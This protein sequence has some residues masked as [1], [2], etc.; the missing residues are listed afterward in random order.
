MNNYTLSSTYYLVLENN[1]CLNENLPDD[2][3]VQ[4]TTI[5]FKNKKPIELQ[6]VLIANTDMT[7]DIHFHKF[8]E[9]DLIITKIIDKDVKMNMNMNLDE[10]AI[11]HTF[12]ENNSIHTVEAYCKDE[13]HLNAH[14]SLQSGYA[15]LSD[16][17]FK[18]DYHYYLDGEGAEAKVRM[19]ILSKQKENKEY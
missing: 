17:S 9:A 16:G 12:N 7:Y 8:V 15:E 1:K 3:T 10:G 19:A 11:V 13:V 5:E 4:G 6:I 18:A 2:I 14:A